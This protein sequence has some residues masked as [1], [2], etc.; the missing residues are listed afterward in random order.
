MSSVPAI[1][2]GT[3]GAPV[4]SAR[5]PTPRFGLAEWAR[6]H[7]RALGKD[8]DRPAL[9]EDDPRRLHRRL[10]GLAAPDREGAERQEDP[11]L[12]ALVEQLDLGDEAQRAPEAAPDH[13]R[14]REAAV[15]GGQQ[16]RALLGHVLEAHAPQPEVDVE[17]GLQD[18]PH[19][20]VHGHDGPAVAGDLMGALEL[21]LDS[22][23]YPAFA[24]RVTGHSP[25]GRGTLRG[26]R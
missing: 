16:H 18:R 14:V 1:A 24:R 8:A 15:V 23:E 26:H 19:D 12:P 3:M 22:R 25:S 2:T 6:P 4:S 21:H 17:E 13:E 7:A 10:V 9:L 11:R 20:P 5:R